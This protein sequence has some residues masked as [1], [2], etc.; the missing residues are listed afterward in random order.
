[1]ILQLYESSLLHA[2]CPKKYAEKWSEVEASI[3]QLNA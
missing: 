1:M 3:P 2:I